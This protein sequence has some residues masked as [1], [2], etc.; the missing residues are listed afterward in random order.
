MQGSEVSRYAV[1]SRLRGKSLRGPLQRRTASG[2]SRDAVE[3]VP[4]WQGGL[5]YSSALPIDGIALPHTGGYLIRITRLQHHGSVPDDSRCWGRLHM[6]DTGTAS[7][8][9]AQLHRYCPYLGLYLLRSMSPYHHLVT[10]AN[11]VFS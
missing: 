11:R 9:P 5:C 4:R 6:R 3:E 10:P 1:R 7:D 8:L 2:A